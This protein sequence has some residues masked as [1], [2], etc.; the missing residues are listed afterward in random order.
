VFKIR[1]FVAMALLALT[2]VATGSVMAG[3]G[4]EGPEVTK[5]K[6]AVCMEM[7]Q[8][9]GYSRSYCDGKTVCGS[10]PK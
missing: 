3:I 6:Y 7:C 9:E 1:K 4:G 5:S 2:S 8:D 10:Y